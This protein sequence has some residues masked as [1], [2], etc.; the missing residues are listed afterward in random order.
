MLIPK[1][2]HFES[3]NVPNSP[4]WIQTVDQAGNHLKPVIRC[5]CGMYLGIGLH[6]VHPDGRVTASFFHQKSDKDPNG[7]GWHVYI[8]LQNWSGEEFWGSEEKR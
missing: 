5:N 1:L 6:H 7:C 8:E 3:I 2:E 4:G